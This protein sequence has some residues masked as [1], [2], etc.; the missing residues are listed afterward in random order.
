MGKEARLIV[1]AGPT[2][3]GKSALALAAARRFGGTVINAAD[4][5]EAGAT[6][7]T[8]FQVTNTG[9]SADITLLN[10]WLAAGGNRI[11]LI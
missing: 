2:A 9:D 7:G 11:T 5:T 1:I 3:S 6:T 10:A 4:F 8:Y